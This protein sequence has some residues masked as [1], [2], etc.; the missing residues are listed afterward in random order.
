MEKDEKKT[1][2]Q[3][4]KGENRYLY[5]IKNEKSCKEQ[6]KGDKFVELARK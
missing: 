1:L 5:E 4:N 3:Q 2:Y 6:E